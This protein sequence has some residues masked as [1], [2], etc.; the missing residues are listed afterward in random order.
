MTIFQAAHVALKGFLVYEFIL[1]L[2]VRFLAS[3]IAGL[4]FYS[5]AAFGNDPNDRQNDEED[6]RNRYSWAASSKKVILPS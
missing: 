5:K 2:A 4:E 6:H 1:G 3:L